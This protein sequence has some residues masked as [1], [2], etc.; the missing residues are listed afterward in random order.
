MSSP[1]KK[2]WSTF[3]SQ[4]RVILRTFLGPKFDLAKHEMMTESTWI[5][6]YEACK[7][8]TEETEG[9]ILIVHEL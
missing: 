8:L 3:P 6:L 4:Y 5:V 2:D 1:S 7:K 9:P